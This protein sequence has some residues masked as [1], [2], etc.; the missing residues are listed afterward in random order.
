MS[1]TSN[2]DY[3]SPAEA[4]RIGL[5][6][7]A[8]LF[9][10]FKWMMIGAGFLILFTLLLIPAGIPFLLFKLKKNKAAIIYIMALILVGIIG[11]LICYVFNIPIEGLL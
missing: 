1:K 5:K 4:R 3:V 11:A 2:E 6:I 9:W 7:Q 8:A 10:C